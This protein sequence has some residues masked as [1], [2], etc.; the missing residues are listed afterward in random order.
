M[1]IFD[2]VISKHAQKDLEKV[3]SYVALKLHAWVDE[4][5]ERGLRETRKIPGYHDEPLKG[6]RHGQRSIRLSKHYRAIYLIN[7]KNII[8][9]IEIIEVNK[10][11]Y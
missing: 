6:K 2:I 8:H 3:P 1:D 11:D 10:H 5:E 7:E 4:V 9:F